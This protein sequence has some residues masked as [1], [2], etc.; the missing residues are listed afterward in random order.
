[1]TNY[2]ILFKN[3]TG[4]DEILAQQA[5]NHLI[6][7][8]DIELF[9]ILVSKS[10]FLFDFVKTNVSKR[11]E[12]ATNQNNFENIINFFDIYS[13]DYDDL[14]AQLL[15]KNA[16]EDL[17]DKIFELLEN[18]SIPQKT[19]A[20]KYFSYIPDTI[21]IEALSK[22]AFSDNE[23]L[24]FNSAEA[25]G[26]MQDDISYEKALNTLNSND[27]FEQLK[28]VKF[29]V[30][31]GKNYPLKEIFSVL[32]N[33]KIPENIAG[34]I[35]YMTNLSKL[36]KSEF[37]QDA[38]LAL[39]Y[40]LRGFGEIL[41]LCD[42]FQFELYE[43]FEYL[44]SQN[45]TENQYSARI[46]EI[47]LKSLLKFSLFVENQEYVFDETKEVKYE[48]TSILKLLKAQNNE[49]W[50][51]QKQFIL[52]EL[53]SSR[54]EILSALPIIV[55]LNM[56]CAIPQIKNLLTNKDEIIICEAISA[57]SHFNA[58]KDINLDE[59][60]TKIS[61]ENIKAIINSLKQ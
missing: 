46:S 57:L 28:A 58:L 14:F 30:A 54:E 6:N 31:Y 16:N 10:D 18:G 24:S 53:N 9:N 20:A 2:D 61:N 47:L 21:S 25:L 32:Q 26:Q 35:P 17:T 43:I 45:E 4:K 48:I 29:F 22:Y 42:V 38:L 19:Y 50:I 49:F 56:N 34:Q 1:M 60:I 11:I 12:K 7:N 3:L 44:I 23:A 36:I 37:K 5:A 59:I 40:I 15:A 51:K 13:T 41:P 52:K 55:E 39:D 27:D 8:S 33:S